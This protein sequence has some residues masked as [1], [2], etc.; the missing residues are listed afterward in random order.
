MKIPTLHGIIDRRILINFTADP[1]VVR[2]IIPNPFSPKIYK[3]KAIVGI[4]LIRLKNL[5]PKG[6]L[7]FIGIS[8]EN[9]AHRIAVEW[10]ENGENREGVYVPRRDTSS[11]L[12]ALAGG[13]I[14]PGKHFQARFDV[15]EENGQ[16]HVAFKSSDGTS[17]AIDG[18]IAESLNPDSIFQ[19]L[20][21]ASRFFEN[22]SVGYSPDDDRFDGLKLET[23][24]W[25]V[26]PLKVTNV[27]SSF[28]EDE[29]VFPKGSIQ[30][31]NALLMTDIEHE[32]HSV[33]QKNRCL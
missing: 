22:G 5:R 25:K 33:E 28:F 18:A 1:D 19:T 12:N 11:T 9:G 14:F 20:D 27:H 3:D 31:D 26:S 16:Y 15:R 21:I 23:F 32:W 8:S 29:T 30:F 24:S 4:C 17:I 6:L 13:R 10:T 2:Q 7:G